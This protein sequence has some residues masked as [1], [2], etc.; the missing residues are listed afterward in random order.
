MKFRKAIR[1]SYRNI[2]RNKLRNSLVVLG[3][4]LSVIIGGVILGVVYGIKNYWTD[5]IYEAGF[6][7]MFVVSGKVNIGGSYTPPAKVLNV[8]DIR[9][10]KQLPDVIAASPLFTVGVF[11]FGENVT[12]L[13]GVDE[14]ISKSASFLIYQ[15]RFLNK[16]DENSNEIPVVLGYNVWK[17][18]LGDGVNVNSTMSLL[19]EPFSLIYGKRDSVTVK[20]KI[21]GLLEKRATIP[22]L[23]IDPNEVFY[24]TL[25]HAYGI[26]G[27]QDYS[28]ALADGAVVSASTFDSLDK[29]SDEIT[30]FLV[31]KGYDE[32]SDF[33]VISQ[34]DALRYIDRVFFQLNNFI[35]IIWAIVIIIGALSIL[36]VMVITVR[37][38][39]RE[40]GT[41]RAL[42]AKR[43][44]ILLIFLLEASYL[45]LLGLLLGALSGVVIIEVLKYYFEFVRRVTI[46]VL[47]NTYSIILPE[48]FL[49]S[50][51]FA[52]YPAYRA[53]K[54]EPAQ[55]LRYE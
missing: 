52:L 15:G 41:L 9:A 7:V 32:R 16:E 29:V 53:T 21:I 46:T 47:L 36:I 10:F 2:T 20:I 33:S 45:A 38:R 30:S 4:I 40:I 51:L 17:E 37:E 28:R 48:I 11:R 49:A 1:L 19:L 8:E 24:T 23:G 14:D 5:S 13:I 18:I 34:K 50:L 3:I 25:K 12:Y 35:S 55:A 27:I 22:G 26:F 42:G 43:S 54:I 39:Y 44:D 31:D 6:N